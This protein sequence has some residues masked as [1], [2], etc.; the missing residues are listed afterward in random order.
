MIYMPKRK[1]MNNKDMKSIGIFILIGVGLLIASQ[2][3]FKIDRLGVL[4]VGEP[5]HIDLDC[6]YNYC[7]DYTEDDNVVSS[8]QTA[9]CSKEIRCCPNDIGVIGCSLMFSAGEYDLSYSYAPGECGEGY[10]EVYCEETC[11]RYDI[12]GVCQQTQRSCDDAVP[13]E[14]AI[15][16]DA[17][18]KNPVYLGS[19]CDQPS[20][21][22]VCPSSGYGFCQFV[23]FGPYGNYILTQRVNRG[24]TASIN[25]NAG[26][27][28]EMFGCTP[29]G[30][31]EYTITENIGVCLDPCAGGKCTDGIC[32]DL[33]TCAIAPADCVCPNGQVCVGTGTIAYCDDAPEYCHNGIDDN[34]NG[35]V[36]CNDPECPSPCADYQTPQCVN[37]QWICDDICDG[38]DTSCG[39]SICVNCNLMDACI[40]TDSDGIFDAYIDYGCYN[41]ECVSTTD[42]CADCSC[43]CGNYNQAEN[44]AVACSDGI[45]NDCDG[46]ADCSD[47]DCSAQCLESCFNGL[48]DDS[49]GKTDC[50]D[51]DCPD[52][53]SVCQIATC[54]SNYQWSCTVSCSLESCI[55]NPEVWCASCAQTS[56]TSCSDNFDNDCDG[57]TDCDDTECINTANCPGECPYACCLNEVIYNDKLCATG[58][59]CISNE[60]TLNVVSC[61][62]QCCIDEAIYT[63]V[64]CPDN[65]NCISHSCLPASYPCP[66]QCCVGAGSYEDK[67][68]SEDQYCDNHICKDNMPI[69]PYECCIDDGTHVDK[70]CVSGYECRSH[71]CVRQE[72]PCPYE[73][74]DNDFGYMDEDCPWGYDCRSHICYKDEGGDWDFD[75]IPDWVKYGAI[76]L[77]IILVLK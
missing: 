10:L 24:D 11:I 66:Y 49:D 5:C 55:A 14:D 77:M 26:Y 21:I 73:C 60:C 41:R 8:I 70:G 44:T 2:Y 4:D 47:T 20:S 50:Q 69:C 48:D 67:L 15:Y 42:S 46:N 18:C 28:Y 65:Y 37:N 40:D 7:G 13:Y 68:C 1:K 36:D 19:S 22:G 35:L 32:G 71:L 30:S 53:C 59:E 3:I 51:P 54:G 23:E 63:E 76:F 64:T 61:P 56:E 25:C 29:V 62:F 9:F 45:D 74:C 72:D 75:S 17:E 33:E 43:S 38:T 12:H 57:F 34:N 6:F 16:L 58:Y 27:K 52:P 39:E 31:C